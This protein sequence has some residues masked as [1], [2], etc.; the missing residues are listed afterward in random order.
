MVIFWID[1]IFKIKSKIEESDEILFKN[2][3]GLTDP[4]DY[5]PSLDPVFSEKILGVHKT[6]FRIFFNYQF[7]KEG[8]PGLI[9]LEFISPQELF[10]Y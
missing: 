3:K 6:F 4:H 2:N 9:F 7:I 1:V 10:I 8:L 5:G